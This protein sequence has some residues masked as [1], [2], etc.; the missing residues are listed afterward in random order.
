M[1]FFLENFSSDTWMYNNVNQ[2]NE[3]ISALWQTTY[4]N[5]PYICNPFS[6]PPDYAYQPS[7]CSSNT[8]KI[9]NIPKRLAVFTCSDGNGGT[10]R[11]GEFI[12]SSDYNSGGFNKHNAELSKRFP[13]MRSLVECQSVNDAF[14]EILLKHSKPLKRFLHMVWIAMVFLLLI[15]TALIHHE[16]E[17]HP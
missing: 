14:S 3:G 4:S 10:C 9:G 17:L 16:Q 15:W 13:G 1:Y 12:S 6:A 11:G 2:V 8:I 7:N 5:L